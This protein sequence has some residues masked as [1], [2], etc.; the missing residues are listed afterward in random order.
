MGAELCNCF[1]MWFISS[2]HGILRLNPSQD[3]TYMNSVC[4]PCASVGSLWVLKFPVQRQASRLTGSMS[5]LHIQNH[6]C[7]AQIWLN[8][9][10]PFIP[11]Y[12]QLFQSICT[13]SV[14]YVETY[15]Y[16][17]NWMAK[18]KLPFKPLF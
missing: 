14:Q 7:I 3:T 4:S 1:Y 12:I 8:T 2:N 17:S 5:K 15:K 9:I 6:W 13:S 11:N 16:I 18:V 10:E